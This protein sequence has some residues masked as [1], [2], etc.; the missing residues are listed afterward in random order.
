[1]S[2]SKATDQDISAQVEFVKHQILI[3][4]EMMEELNPHAEKAYNLI[5]KLT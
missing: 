2:E 5:D 1:M 4:I 3:L